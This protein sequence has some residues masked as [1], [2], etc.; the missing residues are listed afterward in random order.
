[1]MNQTQIIELEEKFW[2]AMKDE[3]IDGAVSLTRFP[4][5]ITGPQGMRLVTEDDFR[6]MM[7]AHSGEVFQHIE[8]KNKQVEF[9]NDDTAIITYE[10]TMN[11][12]D[13][14]DVSTWVRQGN[15]WL[16]A[17]HSENPVTH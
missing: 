7:G 6:T 10:T 2:Q 9:L 13:L 14:L 15:G 4:C 17:F 11:G 8:L 1:M 5:V 3:D 16:C 12:K